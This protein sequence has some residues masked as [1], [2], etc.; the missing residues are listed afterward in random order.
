MTTSF[1]RIPNPSFTNPPTILTAGIRKVLA[2]TEQTVCSSGWGLV[3]SWLLEHGLVQRSTM[4]VT[5][6]ITLLHYE[7]HYVSHYYTMYDTITLCMTL[8]ITLCM[9][10][11]ITLFNTLCISHWHYVCM[12]FPTPNPTILQAWI[13]EN[14]VKQARP[15]TYEFST[16]R[17][18]LITL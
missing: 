12:S 7:S 11:H 4:R 2:C 13:T 17:R 10:L 16:P 6:C 15:D 18:L 9:T 14:V 1:H 3:G 8:C 5:L